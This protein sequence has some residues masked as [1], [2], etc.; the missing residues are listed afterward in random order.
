MDPENYGYI[1]LMKKAPTKSSP[2]KR[3]VHSNPIEYGTT[4]QCR[5]AE[6]RNINAPSIQK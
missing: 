6:E 3:P 2:L 4:V 1:I 5:E